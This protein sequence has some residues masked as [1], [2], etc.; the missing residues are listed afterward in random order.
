MLFRSRRLWTP[1]VL[2][3]ALATFAGL[4][5]TSHGFPV[6]HASLNNGGIWVTNSS[7]GI[8]GQFVKP[9]AQ[10]DARIAPTSES[11]GVNVWQ[12][13]PAVA[14]YDENGHRIYAVNASGLALYDSG[15]AISPTSGGIA[16]GDTTLAVLSADH[17]LRATALG[18]GGGTLAALAPTAKPL[19]TNLPAN[20]AV[21][22]G[23]DDTI[24]VAGGGELR[25]FYAGNSVPAVSSLLLSAAD[26]MQVAT[27]GNVPVVADAATGRLYLPDS[28]TVVGLPTA[29]GLELQ[30]SS[31]AS[32]VV[33]AATGQALY[34]VNLSTGQ[35]TTLSTG[36]SG[37]VAAPVQLS[38]CVYAAWA[39]TVAGS[40]VQTC[41]S[42][43]PA[44][45]DARAFPVGDSAGT[46]SLVFRVNEDSVVL[47]DTTDGYVFFLAGNTIATV[48]PQ[49]QLNGTVHRGDNQANEPQSIPLTA[50]P[51]TQGVRPGTTTVVHVLDTANGNPG[52]TYAVTGLGLPDQPGVHVTIAPDAQTVLATVTA[53][54][55]D[56]HFS[57]TISDGHTHSASSEVTLVPRGPG[58]NAAPALRVNYQP[59]ALKVAAGGTLVAPVIGDWRDLDGDPLYIDPSSVTASAGSAAVTSGG[60]L[61]FTAPPTSANETVTVGYAVS[62]GRVAR[63]TRASL[64]ISVIGSSSTQLIAPVAEPDAALAVAGAPVT[65]SPLANDLSG[66]DPTN[67]DARLKLATAVPAVTGAI[68]TSDVATGAVTFT[69]QQPGDFFLSYIDAYGAAPTASGTIRVHV[70]PAT[71]VPL[72]PV[73]TP[74]VAVLHG[75]QPAVVDVLANDYDPQG[76][77]LG[78]TGAASAAPGVHV[79]VV[80]QRWLRVSASDPVPGMTAAVH[81][82][83]SDGRKSAT[84]TVA[85]S[86]VPDTLGTDQITTTQAAVTVR[87]GDSASVPVLAGDSSSTGLA[88]AV[89]GVPPTANPPVAGLLLGIQGSDIRVVAP[90]GVTAETETAVS[91]VATDGDGTTA[92]G[93]IDVTIMPPPTKASPDQAPAPQEVDARETAGDVVVIPVPVDGVDPDGDSVT[94]TGIIS[95]PALGRIVAVG[96]DS[97]SYQSYPGVLGTDTFEYQVTDRYGLTG[98]AQV[99]AAVLPPGLP[100]PPVAVSDPVNAPP[101]ASL[102]WNVLGN[103]FIAPG[104]TAAI[105]PLSE[106]NS[107]LPAG[108]RLAGSD[109]YVR[110]PGSPAEPAVQLT[111]GLTDGATPSLAQVVVHAVTG[112]QLPPAASDVIVPP[113]AAGAATVTVNVL[114]DDDDPVGSPADLKVS[115]VPAGITVHGAD[116]TIPLAAQPRQVPYQVIAPDGLTATAVV[117]VPGTAVPPIRLKANARIVVKQGGAVTVPLGSVLTDTAGRQLKI[118]TVSQLTAAPAGE[119]TAT[120]NQA[121]ALQVQALGDYS[122]P[123][124]VTVQVY[125]GATPQATGGHTAAVTIPVQVGSGAPVLRCTADPLPAAEGGAPRSWNIGQLCQVWTTDPAAPVS[126]AVSW[127]RPAGG[128]RASVSDGSIL[129]LTATSSAVPGGTGTLTVTPAGA[130]TGATLNVA[131]TSAPLPAGSPVSVTLKAGHSVTVDL[132]QY[133]TSPLAQPEIQVVAVSAASGLTVTRNGA[134]VTIAAAPS[135]AVGTVSLAATVTDVAGRTDREI[136]VPIT[137]NVATASGVPGAPGQPTA[138]ASSRTIVVSFGSAAPNGAPVEYYTVYANGA[139]HQCAASPCTITGLANGTSYTIYVTA[140]NSAGQGARSA[141]TSARP[142]GVPGQVTGLST[143]AGNGQV[144]LAWQPVTDAGVTGYRVE[145]SPPP[146]GQQQIRQVGLATSDTMTG[147][148]NGT[149]YTF[150]V[151]AVNAEGDGPWSLGVAATPFGKP[152]APA[153]PTATATAAGTVT[154]SWAPPQNNGTT[155]T[156]YT[157]YE[158]QA[159]SSAGPWGTQAAS[160][161]VSGSTSSTSF[162]VTNGNWYEYAVAATSQAGTTAQ[163]ALSTPPV[164]A[165]TPPGAPTGLTATGQNNAVSIRFTAAANSQASTIEYGVNGPAES[166]TITGP[167]TAGASYTE[168]ITN[169]MDSSIVNGTPVTIYLAECNSAGQCSTWAGPTAQVTPSGPAPNPG[170]TTPTPGPG[171]TTPTPGPG[172]TTPT[173]G[174]GPTTPT[175]GPGPT[176][177]T[178]GP[179]PTTPGTGPTT[180]TTPPTTT[181]PTT[182]PP[183][184]TGPAPTC[185]SATGNQPTSGPPGSQTVLSGAAWDAGDVITFSVSSADG[186]TSGLGLQPVT[187]GSSGSW[188]E[189]GTIPASAAAG[190]TYTINMSD[191]DNCPQPTLTFTVTGTTTTPPTTTPP[192]TAPPTT[193]PPTTPPP[194][195]P[196]A[197]N[198]SVNISPGSGPAGSAFVVSGAGWV[199]GTVISFNTISGDGDTSHLGLPASV[200]TGASGTWQASGNIP[201]TAKTSDIYDIFPQDTPDHCS[202]S[203]GPVAGFTVTGTPTPQPDVITHAISPLIRE[204]EKA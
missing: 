203:E 46:P 4:A 48:K 1:V 76:W 95:A 199:P 10:L 130:A 142:A 104:D 64:K 81:Y 172:P 181:P 191:S 43:P 188:Q 201:T 196:A 115:W 67:R 108:V 197:C 57:Y 136:S 39:G 144:L 2:G 118:T 47:N 125:D 18:A 55:T 82:T 160:Q 7:Q 3:V 192:T 11:A 30:Q 137:V 65:L 162:A 143:T 168:T 49:W 152:T 178:P 36:H 72:P 100:Q 60:A 59:P 114:K 34:S 80:G 94:V 133:V 61:S 9:I 159:T 174:P 75:V 90:A 68:V 45:S 171:P 176:T 175:P 101:G 134:L 96:P 147:L 184:T 19:A 132:S 194:T 150:A 116:L 198:P 138:T 161:T 155:V 111:Y 200:T 153:A 157:V 128:V 24:W 127:A 22:V 87:A 69:A 17:T 40:Y 119:L 62:D 107:A 182:T 123:G 71:G 158:Y 154:V 53:L 78:V 170:P 56:V 33:I 190:D 112:A 44:T 124:A 117:Y 26:P 88:L 173:P 187:V 126:Y 92:A 129:Q 20:A 97:V 29:S 31:G 13:G 84:G 99:R 70:L 177:P 79:A 50:S 109:I 165:G 41:G 149:T 179:G 180:P 151:M 102:H 202:T 120:A 141:T 85:V 23:T 140:T 28:G 167:F 193:A 63:P 145:I 98:V 105:E 164:Q 77:I 35:L 14:T 121:T 110:V 195:T 37:V 32:D 86:A 89:D 21:A 183:T 27:V 189:T 186:D 146:A 25:G 54:S 16:L 73:T 93:S 135:R 156:G 83:V 106:A 15:Q 122:G 148:T 166:G 42:P 5:A 66:V 51:V 38:G 185:D 6:Q 12:N 204:E 58:Q 91:Y 113:P 74:A 169:A 52:V 131:V 163:S 8:V 139:P 103:D